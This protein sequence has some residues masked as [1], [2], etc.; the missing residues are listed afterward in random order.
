M[1]C[2]N[3]ESIEKIKAAPNGS[4]ITTCRGTFLKCDNYLIHVENGVIGEWTTILSVGK[5]KNIWSPESGTGPCGAAIRNIE[6]QQ[7]TLATEKCT[8][9]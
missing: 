2:F 7:T 5:I 3:A 8:C 4:I 1:K 9:Y 6:K